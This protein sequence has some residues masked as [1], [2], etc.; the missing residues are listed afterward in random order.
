MV[1]QGPA[2]WRFLNTRFG[3]AVF[4]MAVDEAIMLAVDRG[5]S[6]P[7]VRVYGWRPPAV[8]FGYAQCIA[9]EVDLGKCRAMGID[10]VRRPTG[11]RAVL[12]WCELTYSVICRS[13]DGALGGSIKEAYRKISA[14][15]VAGIRRLG[16]L[17]EFEVRRQPTP[18]P[19]EKPIAP[20]CFLSTTQYEITVGGRKLVGSAQRRIASVLLQHGSLLLGPEH[21][22]LADLLPLGHSS[23]QDGLR[24]ELDRKTTCLDEELGQRVPFDGAA[25]GVRMGFAEQLGMDLPE[26]TLSAREVAEVDRLVSHRYSTDAW[27]LAGGPKARNPMAPLAAGTQPR[28]PVDGLDGST[29]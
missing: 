15:L 8:S 2:C 27:N 12:H 16:V 21:K 11:G 24:S 17:P 22:R 3:N 26:S 18:S 7:T 1:Q 20:P 10:V 13:D 23:L 14:C 4:N 19:R 28:T 9:R 5:E 6:P 29:R 25:D